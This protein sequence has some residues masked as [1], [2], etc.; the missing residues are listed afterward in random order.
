MSGAWTCFHA[1]LEASGNAHLAASR[2]LQTE[3]ADKIANFVVDKTNVRK[4][5]GS[6]FYFPFFKETKLMILFYIFF[7]V[8]VGW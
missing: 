2:D 6:Y 5:V 1:Q 7:L 8:L 3:V 4:R